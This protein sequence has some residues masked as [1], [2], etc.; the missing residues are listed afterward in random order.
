MTIQEEEWRDVVGYAGLYKISS[1]GKVMSMSRVVWNG[2]KWH[3]HPGRILSPGKVRESPYVQLWKNGT[4]KNFFIHTL[5]LTA[6]VGPCPDGMECCHFP[7]RDPTNN[8]IENL[9]WDTHKEN[10][11]D[12]FFHGT[13]GK[14]VQKTVCGEIH[15]LAKL[16]ETSIREIRAKRSLGESYRKLAAEYGVS[17]VSIKNICLGRTWTHVSA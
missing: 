2:H 17:H 13:T 5:V 3:S 11:H 12:K 4:G 6:F 9:R 8:R 1:L 15:P 10:I 16:T 14:G 7:D